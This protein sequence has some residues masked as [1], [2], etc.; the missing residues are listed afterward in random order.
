MEGLHRL[1]TVADRAPY[2]SPQRLAIWGGSAGGILVGRA[3]TERPDLFAVVLPQV[4][5]MDMVRAEVTPNGVPN[6]PEFGS[7]T[8]EAGF[9]S[10]LA[11]S[12][13]HQIQDGVKY[14]RC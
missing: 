4:G 2:T 13:Y 5:V 3:M 6:I 9:R 1:R 11:M 14:P 7:R 10:L 8:T 12:T